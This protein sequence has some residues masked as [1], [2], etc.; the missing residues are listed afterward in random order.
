MNR[1]KTVP[2]DCCTITTASFVL[3][4]CRF[5]LASLE[6]FETLKN[7]GFRKP[8]SPS[9]VVTLFHFWD[10]GWCSF[11]STTI[12]QKLR[13]KRDVI[14]DFRPF[15]YGQ[16]KYRANTTERLCGV[17]SGTR[18]SILPLEILFGPADTRAFPRVKINV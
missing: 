10:E 14:N 15:L 18:R 3:C 1:Y 7:H 12:T 11:G 16:R 6:V 17:L 8:L 4:V 2:A 5:S 13:E 9:F